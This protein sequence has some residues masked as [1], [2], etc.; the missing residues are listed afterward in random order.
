MTKK[1]TP[2]KKLT[3]KFEGKLKLNTKFTHFTFKC[4]SKLNK[5]T[6]MKKHYIRNY[7]IEKVNIQQNGNYPLLDLYDQVYTIPTMKTMLAV[8]RKHVHE[9]KPLFGDIYCRYNITDD[10]DGKVYPCR[11]RLPYILQT[12]RYIRKYGSDT[13]RAKIELIIRDEDNI[14][15]KDKLILRRSNYS[16]TGGLGRF[17]NYKYTHQLLDAFLNTHFGDDTIITTDIKRYNTEY[18]AYR[19]TPL[20]FESDLKQLNMSARQE[21][22]CCTNTRKE[23]YAFDWKWQ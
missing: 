10:M 16:L 6:I 9:Y 22:P 12:P 23:F 2:Y 20:Y 18:Q 5:V 4:N 14:T 17:L 13:P 8:L 7:E 15:Y 1:Y 11:F 21:M 19:I 3:Q